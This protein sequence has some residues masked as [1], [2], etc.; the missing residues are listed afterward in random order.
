MSAK[1]FKFTI[2]RLRELPTP[3]NGRDTYHDTQ[4]HGLQLRVTPTGTKSFAVRK[5]IDGKP[6][7][8]T[9]GTF[10]LMTIDQART[11]AA[12]A[13]ANLVVGNNPNEVK[14]ASR[15]RGVT[16]SKCRDDYWK[17]RSRA[18]NTV[19]AYNL[20]VDVYLKDWKDSP[21][22]DITRNMVAAR[23]RKIAKT[24]PVAAN[25]VMR[26][27][28]A[29]INFA[30]GEYE[31]KDGKPIIL[32]NP[33]RRISHNRQWSPEVRKQT[34]IRDGDLP[35]FFVGT[36]ALRE[37]AEGDVNAPAHVVADYLEMILLNG[38]RRDDAFCLEWGQ[39]ELDTATY[40]P[41]IH[42]KKKEVVSL[43]I[44]KYILAIL[45]RRF[46]HRMNE[47]VFP[48]RYGHG[49]YDDP[50]TMINWV[51]D[52]AGINFTS[53][54]LRRT[55]LTASSDLDVSDY[56][57][58][59]LGTHSIEGD[60]TGGYIRLSAERMREPAQKV[61]DLILKKARKKSMANV[62]ALPNSSRKK[63]K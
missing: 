63:V 26:H 19:K 36:Q 21:L 55:F 30:I 46:K 5:K 4:Q 50:R 39:I 10:P 45:K 9:L 32:D 25:N 29:F 7:R 59:R 47:F 14:R 18:D 57:I 48:G 17:A 56:V 41:V 58:K 11:E 6:V 16:L 28:R 43:P 2:K 44:P 23:H 13:V 40:H 52:Y 60:V 1:S 20:T 34:I 24:E 42:K 51:K 33:V 15:L 62:V 27:L 49:R 38:L 8:A 61:E 22:K 53:H 54:D 37:T 12:K 3:I 31:T 35:T